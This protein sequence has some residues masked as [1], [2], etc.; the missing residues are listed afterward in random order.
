[1]DYKNNANK[2]PTARDISDTRMR[3][4]VKCLA[5]FGLGHYIYAGESIPQGAPT[6][7]KNRK[8][9]LICTLTM[10]MRLDFTCY[11]KL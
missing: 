8:Q 3:C 10:K 2:E 1:M 4:L 6:F 9:D 11:L 5:M 7:S